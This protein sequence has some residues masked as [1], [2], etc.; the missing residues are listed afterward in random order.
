MLEIVNSKIEGL[1]SY[2]NNQLSFNK[3]IETQLA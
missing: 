2:I 3:R 1:T